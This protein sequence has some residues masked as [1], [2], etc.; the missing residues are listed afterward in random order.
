[1]SLV[2]NAGTPLL[3]VER[4]PST[5]RYHRVAAAALSALFGKGAGLLV[6]AVTVPLTVHYLGSEG[7]GLWITI[8]SAITMFFVLDIGIANTLTNLISKAYAAADNTLAATY[9]A[10][11][12]WLVVGVATLLGLAG[13]VFCRHLDWPYIFHIH[14]PKL[15]H[16]ASFAVA[17]AF[18]VFLFALPTS[19]VSKV[20][21]G[22]QE[23]H[24]A[25]LFATGGSIA[26]LIGILAVLHFHGGLAVLVGVYAG[27][28]A[29]ANLIC[30][31]WICFFHKPWMKPWPSRIRWNLVGDIFHSGSQFFLIQIAGLTVFN[32]DNLIIAHYLSPAQVTP[33]NVTWRLASY[34][35]AVQALVAP[36]LWPAYSEAYAKGDLAWIRSTY[37]RNRWV[38][39]A[40]LIGGCTLVLF[41]GRKI[42]SKWAGPAAVPPVDLLWL[43]CVWM[44]IFSF[45]LNQSCLMGATY[46]VAKQAVISPLSAIVNLFLSILWVRPFGPLGVLLATIVSYV[47]FI[48]AVQAWEVRRILRGDFLRHYQERQ[49]N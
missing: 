16:E 8:S 25:N 7:Y 38:T 47:I 48:V 32:S 5:S 28:A 14:E 27:C 3:A 19:L 29:G 30:L 6:N 26:S 18:V 43:M 46:R 2:T 20:L 49:V 34:V 9:F 37:A 4:S 24:V 22:Y 35:T 42:I 36:A 44:V 15:A 1:M 13:C 41:A 17:A 21:G 10:T 39:I 12:F 11:A 31:F 40:T 33:Y 45:T 23:L